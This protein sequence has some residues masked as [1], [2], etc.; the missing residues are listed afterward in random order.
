LEK[1][2]GEEGRLFKGTEANYIPVYYYYD[3][4]DQKEAWVDKEIF[5][6]W[7]H[8]HFVPEVQVFLKDDY[9][10]A[11]WL[12]DNAPSHPRTSALTSDDGLIIKF[13]LPNITAV[14]QSMDQGVTASM[15]QHYQPTS[16][17]LLTKKT[18]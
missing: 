11:A 12:L 7:F 5:G 18:A 13:L 10:K 9:H 16:E 2:G 8:K 1:G 3:Y 15:K 6:K 14:I 17:L 4:Y